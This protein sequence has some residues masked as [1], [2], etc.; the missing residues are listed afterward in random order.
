MA[1]AAQVEQFRQGYD[2]IERL[3]RRDMRRIWP[4]LRTATPATIRDTLVALTP[5]LSDRYGAVAT[6]MAAEWFES[7]TG[8]TA[9]L[10]DLTPRE[11]VAISTRA[12]AGG[13]WDGRSELAFDRIISA[14]T[15]HSLQPGRSTIARSSSANRMRYAR[16]PEPGACAWCLM[17]ASRGAVYTAESAV[18]V[19]GGAAPA[20]AG[21]RAAGND[22][23]D[24]CRCVAEPARDDSELSYDRGALYSRYRAAWSRG[25]NDRIVAAR[26]RELYGL[27]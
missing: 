12:V 2:A 10:A 22:Y 8:A 14:T 4:Q 23:H 27:P 19:G 11:A 20:G 18:R 7:V 3:I 16:A 21:R 26:M 17:L 6:S 1:T 9:R 15:R 25:D 5:Q 24:D 13:L